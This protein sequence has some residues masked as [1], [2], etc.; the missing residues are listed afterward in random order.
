MGLAPVRGTP[1]PGGRPSN[2]ITFAAGDLLVNVFGATYDDGST[3]VF[4]NLAFKMSS[5]RQ[6]GPFGGPIS[7]AYGSSFNFTGRVYS[8]YG[9]IGDN[10]NFLS[11]LGFWTDAASPPPAPPFRARPPPPP[12]SPPPVRNL[13]RVQSYGYGDFGATYWDDGPYHEKVLGFKLWLWWDLSYI[14]GFQANP[15]SPSLSTPA[16]MCSLG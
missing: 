2:N 16:H 13:G 9:D 10:N 6:F 7:R 5:G 12:R 14:R 1:V 3:R 11:G 8:F 4:S 15:V